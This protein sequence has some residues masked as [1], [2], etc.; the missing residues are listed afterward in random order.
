MTQNANATV[1]QDRLSTLPA[2]TTPVE[3]RERLAVPHI[4]W[5]EPAAVS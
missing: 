1:P 2:P 5:E 3:V 4:W